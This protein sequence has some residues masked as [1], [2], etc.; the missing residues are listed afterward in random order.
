MRLNY[1]LLNSLE[2]LP[3]E[4]VHGSGGYSNGNQ[5]QG[6]ELLNGEIVE[7]GQLVLIRCIISK[8]LK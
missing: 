7:I 8:S 3:E 1:Y 5:R 4:Y 6:R 2:R